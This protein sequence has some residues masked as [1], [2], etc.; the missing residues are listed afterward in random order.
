MEEILKLKQLGFNLSEILKLLTY[1]RLAGIETEDYKDMFLSMLKD[2]KIEIQ[3][4]YNKY[5][6]M[7]IN[8]SETIKNIQQSR[9]KNSNIIGFPVSYLDILKC[10]DCRSKLNI[11]NG[12]IENSMLTEGNAV[13]KCG[14]HAKINYGIF[15]EEKTVRKRLLNG[16]PW[17]SGDDYLRVVS[18]NFINFIYSGMNKISDHLN[19]YDTGSKLILELQHCVGY[20]LKHYI[21]HRSVD[22]TYILVDYDIDKILELKKS[23]ELN[24]E[25]NN[26]IFLC[27]QM[28]RIPICESSI[29][30]IV[31]HWMTKD[32]AHAEK[33]FVLKVLLPLLKK[34]GILV[35]SYP[36]FKT[37]K[38]VKNIDADV[39]SYFNKDKILE[40]IKGL[41]ISQLN[42]TDIGP[43]IENNPYN[44]DI[45]GKEVYQMIYLGIN[46]T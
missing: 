6:K 43:V 36:Y 45:S 20:F 5:K 15:I 44:Y 2:K 25:Y 35:G 32:Y 10:P 40:K 12:I 39:I 27:C 7:N 17:P 33:D 41:G 38:N 29:D 30:I 22:S 28:D 14:Y 24:Q 4:I 13:C 34:E 3:K 42:I 37:M 16:N 1:L 31:D 21:N 8:V 23:L 19:D 18:P 11:K 46:K 26:F 9:T